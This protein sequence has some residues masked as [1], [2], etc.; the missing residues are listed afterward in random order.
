MPGPGEALAPMRVLMISD[1]YFPRIN[2]VSTSIETFRN[3]LADEGV[4]VHLVAPRYGDEA[5]APWIARVPSRRVP[6]DPEDRFMAY[7]ASVRAGLTDARRRWDVVHVHTPFV[8]HYAGLRVARRAGIPLVVTYHTYFEEYLHHYVPFVPRSAIRWLARHVSAS[9]CN[10]VDA[11]A[12]PSR[13]MREKL[14]EYGVRRPMHVLPT[15]IPVERFAGGDGAAFRRRFGIGPRRPLGLFVGRAAFEKNIEFLL[16]VTGQLR[17]RMPDF[18][19]V[20][21]GEGPARA[22]LQAAAA[23]MG[24]ADNTAFV[25]YMDRDSGLRD[26]YAAADVFLFASRTETQ[27]L[28][29]LEAMAAGVPVVALAEMGTRD[30]VLPERGAR[31]ARH[32]VEDFAS[33]TLRVLED[34]A[35]RRAMAVEAREFVAEW[36][37]R[38]MAA[39]LAAL[40]RQLGGAR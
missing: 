12:V 24:L 28:V 31:V 7:G 27:G 33:R 1:V 25:G 6:F 34:G 30:I 35:L 36:S 3:R 19:L 16:R 21:A 26:C 20:V 39:R 15:G 5:A 29:L 37:D 38:R 13:A 23:R 17:S 32:D 8:A 40:Y 18:L 22:Q 14:E 4:D 11:V 10:G 2:G 9:Q